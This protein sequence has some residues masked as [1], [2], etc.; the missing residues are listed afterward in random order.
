M[1]HI[2]ES[3]PVVRLSITV[4]G[5]R[6]WGMGIGIRDWGDDIRYLILDIRDSRLEIGKQAI[7]DKVIRDQ[8]NG[9]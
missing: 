9:D 4:L 2:G 7:G 3:P 6:D 5:I 8:V 1:P